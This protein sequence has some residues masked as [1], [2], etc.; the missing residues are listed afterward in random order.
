LQFSLHGLVAASRKRKHQCFGEL[1][2]L[3][4]SLF[5][6]ELFFHPLSAFRW[7]EIGAHSVNSATRRYLIEKQPSPRL[8]LNAQSHTYR[9]RMILAF[10]G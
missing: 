2:A 4:N 1:L 6:V 10:S 5:G 8:A 3:A 7:G 9:F